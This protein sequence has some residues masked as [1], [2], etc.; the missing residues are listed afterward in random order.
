MMTDDGEVERRVRLMR[1]MERPTLPADMMAQT[2]WRESDRET[3]ACAWEREV[4]DLPEFVETTLHVVAGLLL[5]IWKRLPREVQPRLSHP[6]RRR[7]AHRRAQ[8]LSGLGR[9]RRR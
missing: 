3:F 5:P 4:A 8:G 7:R 1:P 2:H 9:R 6:D